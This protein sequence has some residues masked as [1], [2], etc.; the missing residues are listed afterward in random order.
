MIVMDVVPY[1]LFSSSSPGNVDDLKTSK[2]N[3]IIDHT[4]LDSIIVDIL[5]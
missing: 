4:H 5:M 3:T 1:A 2:H